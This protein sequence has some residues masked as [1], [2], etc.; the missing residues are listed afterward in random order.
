MSKLIE[1]IGGVHW[2]GEIGWQNVA[3]E[4]KGWLKEISIAPSNLVT[5]NQHAIIWEGI[6][7]YLINNKVLSG[8]SVT[9]T[10][11]EI[12]CHRR[13]I[14]NRLYQMQVVANCAQEEDSIIGEKVILK[15][16]LQIIRNTR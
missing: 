10:V 16:N 11:R 8:K 9:H 15:K 12:N 13:T 5:V 2:P 6:C 1:Y 14:V 4:I 3:K 7:N